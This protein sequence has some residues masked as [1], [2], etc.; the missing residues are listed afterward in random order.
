VARTVS[1]ALPLAMSR[2]PSFVDTNLFLIPPER[3][4]STNPLGRVVSSAVDASRCS[5]VWKAG[6][7]DCAFPGAKL[8]AMLTL[9]TYVGATSSIRA[10]NIAVEMAVA[11]PVPGGRASAPTPVSVPSTCVP[12]A[13]GMFTISLTVPASVGF[14]STVHIYALYDGRRLG[15]LTASP[16]DA[17]RSSLVWEGT[18]AAVLTLVTRI[19]SPARVS[20]EDITLEAELSDSTVAAGGAGGAGVAASASVGHTRIPVSCTPRGPGLFGVSLDVPSTVTPGSGIKVSASVGG[21]LVHG[22]PLAHHVP[23]CLTFDPASGSSAFRSFS[24]DNTTLTAVGDAGNKIRGR[25]V[26]LRTGP[27]VSFDIGLEVTTG[28]IPHFCFITIDKVKEIPGDVYKYG[29]NPAKVFF[30]DALRGGVNAAWGQSSGHPTLQGV[31]TSH[32]FHFHVKGDTLTFSHGVGR[33]GCA[34][35][36]QPKSWTLPPEFYLLIVAH[37]PGYV[38]RLFPL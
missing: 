24:A 3:K 2:P 30:Y 11:G 21:R 1:A 27:G 13:S 5:L 15:Q 34:V 29:S 28:P 33:A 10:D 38:F 20:E 35:T 16:L 19:G 32:V 18:A 17:D 25:S 8:Y 7:T 23:A 4:G 14:G 22:S 12:A 9:A 37:E 6:S 26:A 36:R 31:N